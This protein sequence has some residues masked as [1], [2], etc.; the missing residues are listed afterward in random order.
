MGLFGLTA[1]YNYVEWINNPD[2][3]PAL[4]WANKP[5]HTL[6]FRQ[7]MEDA[8]FKRAFVDHLAVYMGDFLNERGTRAVWDPMYEEVK[9]EL[10]YHFQR[11]NIPPDNYPQEMEKARTWLAQRP[12]FAYQQLADYYHLGTP[13]PLTVNKGAEHGLRTT[14]NNIPIKSGYFDGMYFADSL[15]TLTCT[16]PDGQLMGGWRIEKT[17]ED[18]TVSIED[19]YE[20]EYTFAMPACKSLSLEAITISDIGIHSQEM[21]S[22]QP[23]TVY[24]LQ[25]IPQTH[26][27]RGVNIIDGKKRLAH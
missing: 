7:L 12:T 2:Y 1:D 10:P 20:A 25:G 23:H 17:E 24:S 27:R 21:P 19:V 11:F 5:E 4:N 9:T 22:T 14:I 15:L 8:D 16:R 13:T 18:G 3:D 6:L 26:A